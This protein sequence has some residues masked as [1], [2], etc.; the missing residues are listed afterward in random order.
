MRPTSAKRGLVA[1]VSILVRAPDPNPYEEERLQRIDRNRLHLL[2]L[3]IKPLSPPVKRPR[4]PRAKQLPPTP[5][6]KLSRTAKSR[7]A[8]QQLQKQEQEQQD[9][10]AK[11]LQR[12][13]RFGSRISLQLEVDLASPAMAQETVEAFWLQGFQQNAGLREEPE[14][15]K[16]VATAFAAKRITE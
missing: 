2:G 5:R 14:A 11:R 15:T 6:E 3:G 9:Q 7:A 10:L 1:P 4:Q 16:I 12:S 13:T 8:A